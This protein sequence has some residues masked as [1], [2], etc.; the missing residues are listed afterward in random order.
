MK[1]AWIDSNNI[2]RNIIVYD[3]IAKYSPPEGYT[4]EE[5]NDWVNILDSKDI[6]ELS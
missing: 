2:V 5:I 6:P 3:G 4:L 1:W